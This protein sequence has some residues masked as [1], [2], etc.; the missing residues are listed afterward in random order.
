[1]I[2]NTPVLETDR[3]IL[4]RGI[5]DDY[6]I[7]YEYDFTKLRDINGEFVYEKLNVDDIEGF[8]IPYDNSYDW[9]I[10]LKDGMVPIGNVVADREVK[11]ISAIELSFNTH[12]K[13][14]RC[15]Y[16]KEALISIFEFLF[17]SGYDNLLCSYDLGNIKSKSLGESLGFEPYFVDKEAYLKDGVLIDTYVTILSKERYNKIY[18]NK[19]K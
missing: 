14:W 16:T 7:V 13:Y 19:I 17:K 2:Y 18:K 4:K 1:M 5:F 3:L 9:I 12:P 15:G 6:K 11:D 10:Y 8:D